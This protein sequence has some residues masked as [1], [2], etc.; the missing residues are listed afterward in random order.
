MIHNR[1]KRLESLAVAAN[2]GRC[3]ACAN[4]RR[5]VIIRS[6]RDREIFDRQMREREQR[7]TC[8]RPFYVKVI[9]IHRAVAA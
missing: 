2:F 4:A 7:C 9:T 6:E 1:L 8:D 3:L 5:C